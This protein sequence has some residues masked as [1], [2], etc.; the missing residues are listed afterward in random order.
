[1]IL[2]NRG[3]RNRKPDQ[4]RKRPISTARLRNAQNMSAIRQPP[5][6]ISAMTAYGPS[7]RSAPA[8][9]IKPVT[10]VDTFMVR[11]NIAVASRLFLVLGISPRLSH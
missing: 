1:V 11:N 7:S 8:A 10:Y 9:R 2:F 5:G 3:R 6:T 4:I